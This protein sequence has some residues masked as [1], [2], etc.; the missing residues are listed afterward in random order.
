M[1]QKRRRIRADVYKRQELGEWTG[2]QYK[3]E[4]RE[5]N[6]AYNVVFSKSFNNAIV[7]VN[8]VN[9]RYPVSATWSCV[10]PH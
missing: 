6:F 9:I 7:Y 3:R 4:K 1:F 8:N 5:E 10:C 2:S